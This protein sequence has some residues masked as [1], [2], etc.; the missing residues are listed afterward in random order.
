MLTTRRCLVVLCS[1]LALA[2][3]V[4]AAAPAPRPARLEIEPTRIVLNHL[5]DR[6]RIVVTA[7]WSDGSR[8]DHTRAA[9]FAAAAAIVAVGPDGVVAPR[10]AGST[11]ITIRAGGHAASVPVEVGNAGR[12][13][14]SFANDVMPLLAKYGCNA[15]AC[16]GSA[17]G[18]KGF[19]VSLRGYDPARDHLT[20]TRGALGRRLDHLVPARSLL[21]LKPTAQ[22]VHEGGKRFEPGSEPAE[23]LRRWIAEGARSD[24]ATAP[25]LVGLDVSPAFRTFAS[26]GGS[27]QLRVVA[28]FG[29]GTS[30]DVTAW[31]RYASSN[32][33]SVLTHED[34][35]VSLVE[36]GE[37][38]VMVRYGALVAVSNL[39]VLR[40]DPGFRWTTPP[41]NNY[42]DHHVLAKLRAVE[43]L[44][45][46]LC[47]DEEFLRRVGYDLTGLPP[48]PDEVRAFLADKRA[49]RRARK[50]DELLGRAEHAEFWASKWADLLRLR[51]DTSGDKGT[52]STYRWLRDAVAANK[53]HDRF[54]RELLTAEGSGERNAPATYWRV[55]ATTEDA[56]EATAQVFLGIRLMCARCHDHPFEKWVQK[57][58]YG[59]AAFFGQV[60]R[61]PGR[62]QGEIVVFRQDVAAR[63]RHPVT[64]EGLDPKF[65]DGPVT[66]IGPKEDGRKAL[67]DW[68]TRKDNPFLARATVNR[69]WSQLFGRGIIDPVDDIR[70][71]NP[72][73]NPALL[74]AL[75][76]DFLAHDF[77]VR[78]LIRTI[79][80]S[81][82]YQRS[83]RT[84]RTNADDRINF[85][86]AVPRRLGAEQLLD[87]VARI[88]GVRE[89]YRA[90]IPGQPS[91]ALPV[92]G[93]RA[94]GVPDRSLTTELLDLF[95]RPRGESTCSCERSDEANLGHALQLIAGRNVLDRISAPAGKIA[96][97]VRTPK[98]SDEQLCEELYLRVLCRLPTPKEKSIIGK[99]LAGKPNRLEA[100]QDVVWALINSRAFLF[101]H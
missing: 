54:V 93:A 27:Q 52:W 16:H 15:G 87:T 7:V 43:M 88:T 99:H 3:A 68:L 53:P 80:T 29:D 22:A 40:H 71:S 84:N 75:V 90:R 42:V 76:K 9:T 62:R 98:L 72:P 6:A 66:P 69:V 28:R 100:A 86:H 14:V 51:F 94:A 55:F 70:S 73:S 79:C 2:P 65:L 63:S 26:P 41:E 74:D 4:P 97:L 95:G 91:V 89:S 17:S 31:A 11:T 25:R 37:A 45:S 5:D 19:K 101:N 36:R 32:E 23:L 60:A 35:R 34:G 64:G 59:L 20:L 67:A 56:V 44:P 58:Y 81:R 57:D 83:A 30:R 49:D 39:V 13:P 12:R 33:P 46:E 8:T 61:K 1:A 92:T 78:H 50:V 21:I 85:S 24:L 77:D 10:K 18:K 48:A 38:A 82:T 47:T 96:Q